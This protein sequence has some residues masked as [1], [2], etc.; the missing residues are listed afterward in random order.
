[1]QVVLHLHEAMCRSRSTPPLDAEAIVAALNR[2]HVRY[3]TIGA[4]AALL[5]GAILPP[6]RTSRRLQA[7]LSVRGQHLCPSECDVESGPTRTDRR[8][9]DRSRKGWSRD[10][11]YDVIFV[12]PRQLRLH[13][14]GANPFWGQVGWITGLARYDLFAR[15]VLPSAGDAEVADDFY[16]WR[17]VCIDPPVEIWLSH[18]GG[19]AGCRSAPTDGDPDHYRNCAALETA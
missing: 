9:S 8:E 1:M 6:P 14:N 19:V 18:A 17:K 3:V 12:L 2:H 4:F 15:S 10:G 5:P 16:G 13:S 7:V 11:D